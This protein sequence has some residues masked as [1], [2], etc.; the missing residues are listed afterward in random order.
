MSEAERSSAEKAADRRFLVL[1]MPFWPID[2]MRRHRRDLPSEDVPFVLVSSGGR[3]VEIGAVNRRAAADG[4]RIG[5]PLADARAMLRGLVA[6]PAEPRADAT[7]LA[8]LAHWCGRYG[9][10]RN[11]CGGDGIWIDITG[12]AHLYGGEAALAA[13]LRRRMQGF[14]IEVRTG[15]AGTFGAAHAMARHGPQDEMCRDGAGGRDGSRGRAIVAHRAIA[16][17]FAGFPVEALR[18]EADAVLLL[19]RL[20]L[21]RIGQL[22]GIPRASLEQRFHEA[23]TKSGRRP[24]RGRGRARQ[25]ESA[26]AVLLRLD[27]LLGRVP[28]P[29]AARAEP[30]VLEVR[31]PFA[32]ALISHEGIEA[33]IADLARRLVADLGRQGLAAICARVTFYRCDGTAAEVQAA[34]SLPCRDGPHLQRLFAER[35]AA[36]DAGFGIDLVAIEAIRAERI[37]GEQGTIEPGASAGGAE[38]LGRLLDRLV[39]R[40]GPSRVSV[41]AARDSHIPERAQVR[42]AADRLLAEPAGGAPEPW[43]GRL[44]G[45]LRP[46]FLLTPP[47][48]VTVEEEA[49]GRPRA[50]VWRRVGVRFVACEG[51]EEIAPEWWRRIGR[52]GA[53]GR[54]DG[55]ADDVRD[56]YRVEAS[57]GQRY[58]IF[59][60][61]PPAWEA[62]GSEAAPP[63]KDE[64]AA[65]A[66]PPRVMRWFVHGLYGEAGGSGGRP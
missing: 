23:R 11:V 4:L 46:A 54:E 53:G 35:L 38:A 48:P 33:A 29:L 19:K 18:L 40:L 22:Y 45:P 17:A 26:A 41:L 58:W 49:S 3:G 32:E 7:A 62:M 27:Q 2:R 25:G 61:R 10:R 47:E 20:G 31:Q 15:V 1:W 44:P 36:I 59:R 16:D 63:V 64:A 5:Q 57:G 39:N 52:A 12:V 56:Y 37:D 55:L 14:G 13:D 9:P 24:Q 30:P 42:G 8:R 28:E 66:E 43:F 21:R 50:M 51:P 60:A 34:T 65:G 6:R